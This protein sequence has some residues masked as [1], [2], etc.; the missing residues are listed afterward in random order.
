MSGPTLIA[1]R[2][3]GVSEPVPACAK[4]AR[5]LTIAFHLLER[6]SACERSGDQ[7]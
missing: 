6:L 2:A 3:L 5:L 1:A 7:T 4:P